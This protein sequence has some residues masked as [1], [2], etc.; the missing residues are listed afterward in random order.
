MK[1]QS[2]RALVKHETGVKVL[3]R[4]TNFSQADVITA[5]SCVGLLT[6]LLQFNS[7]VVVDGPSRFD[8]NARSLLDISDVHLLVVQLLVPHVRNSVRILEGMRE[9]GCSVE[10]TK[11]VCNRVGRDSGHLSI[12]DVS[13]TLALPAFAS[14]P[15][16]WLAVSGAINLG[17]PI[18]THNPKAKIRMAIQEIAQRLQDS[19]EQTDDKDAAKKGL[20]GRIFTNA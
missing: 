2:A 10:R 8:L 12:R 6:T 11:L 20:I 4:P 15:D 19:D 13:D 3:S 18:L 1:K 17:E 16:D 7:Y 9:A 14:I 5:A